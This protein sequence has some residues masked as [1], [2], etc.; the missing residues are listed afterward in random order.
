MSTFTL[1]RLPAVNGWQ[2]AVLDHLVEH[3]R[4]QGHS[5]RVQGTSTFELRFPRG[6][7]H[8]MPLRDSLAIL[9][10]DRTGALRG[11]DFH[12][13]PDPFD[14]PELIRD[15]RLRVVLK[16]QYREDAFQGARGDV[17]RPWTYF[18]NDWPLPE[19]RLEELRRR[20]RTE[21]GLHFRGHLWKEREPVVRLLQRRGVLGPDVE[22]VPPGDYL[23]ELAR[24]RLILSLPGMGELCHRDVEAFALGSCVLRLQP[25]NRFHEELRP[26]HH[27]VSVPANIDRDPPEVV[28]ERIELRY[29]QVVQNAGYLGF[30]A[31]NA[32]QWYDRNVRWPASMR[33]TEALLDLEP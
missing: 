4:S 16:C 5:L 13:W 10:D 6:K 22:P 25:R 24:R 18:E 11:L 27:F 21:P 12:D 32:Q 20:R 2:R 8:P 14:F 7:C 17:I 33:L 23:E 26:D 15:V 9:E 30:V 3:L 31:H 19:P 29:R 28:A 1:H